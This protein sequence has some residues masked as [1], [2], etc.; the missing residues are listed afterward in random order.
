M[1]ACNSCHAGSD[2]ACRDSDES[3]AATIRD[4]GEMF[5]KDAVLKAQT[6]LDKV[7]NSSGIPIVIET[8]DAIPGL[9]R[10]ASPEKR[11]HAIDALAVERDRAIHDEGIYVLM[12]KRDHVMS[13]VLVRERLADVLPIGKRDAIRDAFVNEFKKADGYD[14]GLL[15][16]RR[17]RSRRHSTEY[18]STVAG[19]RIAKGSNECSTGQTVERWPAGRSTLGTFLMILVG[20]FGVLLVLRLIGGLFRRP[21]GL[22]GCRWHGHARPRNRRRILRRPR[23]RRARGRLLFK[24]PGWLGRC[25][26]RQLAVRPVQRGAITAAMARRMQAK[27][28]IRQGHP[29]RAEMRSSAQTTIRAAEHRGMTPAVVTPE[30]ET[31]VAVATGAEEAEEIGAEAAEI[32]ETHLTLPGGSVLLISGATTPR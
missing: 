24:R 2:I 27:F 25:S 10:N 26:C 29:T 19:S 32:G 12:S 8:I 15:K 30:A 11:R 9:D 16:R 20:I 14:A 13:H 22:S 6:L 5:S 18:P 3:Q 1:V 21:A 7:E 17:K 23:L 28:P 31:G 4:R